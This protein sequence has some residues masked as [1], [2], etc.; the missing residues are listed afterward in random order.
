MG[1]LLVF[2]RRFRIASSFLVKTEV[3]CVVSEG[4]VEEEDDMVA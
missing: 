2:L 1:G 3:L 4:G